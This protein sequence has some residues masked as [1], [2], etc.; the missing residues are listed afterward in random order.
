MKKIHLLAALLIA[1]SGLQAQT[2]MSAREAAIKIADRILASTTYD[3][4]T[5]KPGDTY[6]S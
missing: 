5:T 1:A 3:F 6:K 2:K 4:K